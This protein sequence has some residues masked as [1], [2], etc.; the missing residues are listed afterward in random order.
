MYTAWGCARLAVRHRVYGVVRPWRGV[1][2]DSCVPCAGYESPPLPPLTG[3]R[4]AS[5]SGGVLV[6]MP[7]TEGC[8]DNVTD[9]GGGVLPFEP[10]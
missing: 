5:Y 10:D 8:L 7:G 1:H 2:C 9:V 4:G 6:A 3:L